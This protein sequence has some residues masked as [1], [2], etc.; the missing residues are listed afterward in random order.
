MQEFATPV[1]KFRQFTA[2]QS[3]GINFCLRLAPFLPNF[4]TFCC[5]TLS[6]I[7]TTTATSQFIA[8]DKKKKKEN[9]RKKKKEKEKEKGVSLQELLHL[10]EKSNSIV[11]MYFSPG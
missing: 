6:E 9:K 1:Y 10:V 5:L 3:R 2:V 7:K 8:K 4:V 11:C